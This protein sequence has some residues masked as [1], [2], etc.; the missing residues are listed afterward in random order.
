M[1][2]EY[3]EMER[4][5]SDVTNIDT[6][7][8][9]LRWALERLNNVEKEKAEIKKNLL[10][11]EES[12]KTLDAR[13]GGL[14]QSLNSRLKVIGD[15]EA[16][17]HKLEATM[18]LL[19]EGKLNIEQLI[20][21]EAKIDQIRKGF[22]DDYQDKFE[23]LDKREKSLV[24]NWNKRLLDVEEQYGKRLSAAQNKYDSLRHNL[25]ADYQSRLSSLE[26][27]F[28]D[29][30]KSQNE[31]IISLESFIKAN[32]V[33]DKERRKEFEL[34]FLGR[35]KEL[36]LEFLGRKRNLEEIYIKTKSMLEQNFEARITSVDTE[37]HEQIIALENSW[38]CERQRLL[39]EQKIREDQYFQTQK[40]IEILENQ[41]A[42][43]QREHQI[44]TLNSIS[45]LENRFAEKVREFEKEKSALNE[46][47]QKLSDEF[48]AKEKAWLLEKAEMNKK[49]AQKEIQI[50]NETAVLKDRLNREMTLNI[51]EA[52]RTRTNGLKEKIESVEKQNKELDNLIK[53]K[54]DKIVKLE[55]DINENER[56]W[57]DKVRN[58]ERDL[59][60]QKTAKIQDAYDKRKAVLEE[61]FAAYKTSLEREYNEKLLSAGEISGSKMND[62]SREKEELRSMVVDLSHKLSDVNSKANELEIKAH[63]TEK[64]HREA[65]SE[66]KKE[67]LIQT[68][69][70]IAQAI[71][72]HTA[73]FSS[74][75][76]LS[77]QQIAKIRQ[78]NER[79]IK[80]LSDN[81]NNEKERMMNELEKRG[82]LI[83][84]GNLKIKSLTDELISYRENSSN[85]VMNQLGEQEKKFALQLADFYKKQAEV[86]DEYFNK[87][88]DIKY[89]CEAK[90]DKM[91]MVV[92]EKNE[93][94]SKR[95]NYIKQREE[96]INSREVALSVKT[97]DL[98]NNISKERMELAEREGIIDKKIRDN[99]IEYARK[100]NELEKMKAE[101]SRAIRE[102]KR[103][104][105]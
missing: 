90:I 68:E 75:L 87:I 67:H 100:V 7:R 42:S 24:E 14:E 92:Q 69:G 29:K 48:A 97:D 83:E 34:E 37:H 96:E 36:E 55:N 27:S 74:K 79:E 61:E 64:N 26:Q 105:K 84:A 89:I 30:E 71:E 28:K 12:K 103:D 35:K 93:F 60:S 9:T 54:N 22:E 39:R 76:A 11:A 44:K 46:S 101:L 5:V 15:K 43:Q 19:G 94:I 85:I 99:E 98:N 13:I 49:L 32:E 3:N 80:M 102:H 25:E 56:A 38:N 57:S 21:K 45:D 81:F 91:N 8:M 70:K 59:V 86:E 78:E 1:A 10:I 33:S 4:L 66:I 20:R 65:L 17:Y 104:G 77:E 51:E 53:S 16:F 6:A 2:D 40:K 41:L 63:E 31:R 62:V 95:E 73:S 58:I 52:V 23:E 47:A 82:R 50:E 72:E 88:N 18:Q